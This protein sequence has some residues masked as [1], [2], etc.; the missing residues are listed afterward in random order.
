MICNVVTR[1]L[2]AIILLQPNNKSE[3]II[4]ILKQLNFNPKS[5]DNNEWK[6]NLDEQKPI[7]YGT[8]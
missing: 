3:Y 1:I 2:K 5:K 7:I 8:F 6:R 4:N